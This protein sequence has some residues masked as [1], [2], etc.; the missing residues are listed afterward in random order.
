MATSQTATAARRILSFG[1]TVGLSTALGVVTIPVLIASLGTQDWAQLTLVQTL[2]QVFG[3]VV[4]YGWGAVGPTM[5]ASAAENSRPEIFRSSLLAR[6]II[7]AIVLPVMGTVVF[8]LMPEEWVLITLGSATYLLQFMFSPWYFIGRGK[9]L[10]LFLYDA[11][12]PLVGTAVALYV[13]YVTHSSTA[14]LIVQG[15]AYLM[16]VAIEAFVVLVPADKTAFTPFTAT[17]FRTLLR[18]HAS[19]VASTLTTG[20]YATMP[21]VVVQAFAPSSLPVYAMIDKFYRYGT[22]AFTPVLQFLQSWIPEP[23]DTA[24]RTARMRVGLWVA[25]GF[26]A[27][28]GGLLGALSPFVGSLMSHGDVGISLALSLPVGLAFIAVACS[29]VLSFACLVILGRMRS[30]AISTLIG[31]GLGVPLMTVAAWQGHLLAIPWVLV[32]S[33]AVVALYQLGTF[34]R[35]LSKTTGRP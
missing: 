22:I 27:A 35:T 16:T 23:R 34:T 7:F 24:T 6:G 4:S 33:E 20:I 25:L 2:G 19:A 30:V 13:A 10:Q 12:P 1:G 28:G 31:A 11:M 17:R 5:V 8:C 9:P 15:S 18:T 14:F 32:V 26:G 29:T 3:I 21:M